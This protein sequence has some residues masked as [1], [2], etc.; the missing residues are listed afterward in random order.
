MSG[1]ITSINLNDGDDTPHMTSLTSDFGLTINQ[2]IE[3]V[4]GG[5]MIQ[6]GAELA[7]TDTDYANLSNPDSDEYK[8]A[9]AYAESI[10]AQT[11]FNNAEEKRINFFSLIYLFDYTKTGNQ[12]TGD[13]FAEFICDVSGGSTNLI[14]LKDLIKNCMMANAKGT[15]YTDYAD[16]AYIKLDVVVQ[17]EFAPDPIYVCQV[18][19]I[20]NAYQA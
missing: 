14:T 17:L 9:K 2:I 3:M 7:T 16:Y 1:S 12:I 10:L 11:L 18:Y 4:I 6:S 5:L 8:A 20:N 13:E 15:T 19:T